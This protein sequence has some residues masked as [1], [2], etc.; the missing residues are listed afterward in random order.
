[1]HFHTNCD[2]VEN[3]PFT[4]AVVVL[5]P[6]GKFSSSF[7]SR[8]TEMPPKSV[9][10]Q[11]AC[12]VNSVCVFRSDNCAELKSHFIEYETDSSQLAAAL[13]VRSNLIVFTNPEMDFGGKH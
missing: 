13:N 2:A 7:Y 5:P 12:S 3:F 1:M 10:R 8:H 9:E 4:P 11:N 6:S